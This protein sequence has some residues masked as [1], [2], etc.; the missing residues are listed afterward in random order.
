MK[1]MIM[2]VLLTGVAVSIV[3]CDSLT[4]QD[5]GAVTGGTVGALVGS[6]FGKGYGRTVAVAAGSIAGALI[7]GQ[8]GKSMDKADQK[9]VSRTLESSKTNQT[10][11]WSNPDTGNRYAV[12]PKK[13][14]YQNNGQP[15]RE[16]TTKAWI[17]GKQQTV[18]G[19]AC[20]QADGSWKAK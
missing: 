6:R 1:K 16:Y 3:G 2:V 5:V 12:T 11:S 7:G 17:A 14:N 4:K 20:R 15:C 19:T 13:T 18:Y 8:I 9:Q 10:T